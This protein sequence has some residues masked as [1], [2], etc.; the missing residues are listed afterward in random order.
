MKLDG[1][2][3]LDRGVKSPLFWNVDGDTR[4][5]MVDPSNSRKLKVLD[6]DGE[7]KSVLDLKSPIYSRTSFVPFNSGELLYVGTDRKMHMMNKKGEELWTLE[8]PDSLQKT[9]GA[10]S[11]FY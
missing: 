6:E 4:I 7:L 5:L 2:V 3:A 9:G 8:I 10:Y 11:L 1:T